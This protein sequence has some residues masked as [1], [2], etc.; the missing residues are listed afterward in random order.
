MAF[1]NKILG[2]FLG[3]KSDKDMAEIAPLLALNQKR[4][5]THQFVV[6]QRIESRVGPFKRTD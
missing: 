2:K 6:E 5:R 3:S 1:I 4:I